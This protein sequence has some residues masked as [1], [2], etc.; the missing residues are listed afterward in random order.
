MIK[1]QR[2]FARCDCKMAQNGRS[3]FRLGSAGS[4]KM[5]GFAFRS[6]ATGTDLEERRP[7]SLNGLMRQTSWIFSTDGST[8]KNFRLITHLSTIVNFLKV[9]VSRRSLSPVRTINSKS[10]ITLHDCSKP[11]KIVPRMLG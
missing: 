6:G 3:T 2:C 4:S 11:S 10:N 7:N 8:V 5:E 1:Y 9:Q